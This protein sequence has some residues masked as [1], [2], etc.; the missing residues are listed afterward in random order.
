MFGLPPTAHV[1][2]HSMQ[3]WTVFGTTEGHTFKP[4]VDL[5]SSVLTHLAAQNVKF[6]LID[7]LRSD[8]TS[9]PI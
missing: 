5:L 1:I 9:P 2:S 4:Y 8:F 6:V 7:L 3:F